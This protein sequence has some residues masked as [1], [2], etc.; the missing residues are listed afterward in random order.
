MPVRAKG[1]SPINQ[2]LH[3]WKKVED[4][5]WLISRNL[6]TAETSSPELEKDVLIE[7]RVMRTA[8]SHAS[9]KI[10]YRR[11]SHRKTASNSTEL[12]T[13]STI[14]PKKNY[15][16]S[17]QSVVK[18]TRSDRLHHRS[19]SSSSSY[20]RVRVEKSVK[21]NKPTARRPVNNATTCP[22]IRFR[23]TFRDAT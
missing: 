17:T 12:P 11:D 15:S 18:M 2:L 9:H 20:A 21:R 5:V 10:P 6:W 22:R 7:H 3:L 1:I 4:D 8:I 13:I 19:S 23:R 14:C 16:L